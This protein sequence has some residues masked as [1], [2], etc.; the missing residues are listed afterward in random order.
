MNY[1]DPR[2]GPSSLSVPIPCLY[3]PQGSPGC[4]AGH[5]VSYVCDMFEAPKVK[6]GVGQGIAAGP[7]ETPLKNNQCDSNSCGPLPALTHD[8]D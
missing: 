8:T 4:D 3:A 2:S 7:V 1:L 6:L 5:G